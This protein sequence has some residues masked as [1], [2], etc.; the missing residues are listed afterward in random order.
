MSPQSIPPADLVAADLTMA[1]RQLLRRLR[2]ETN[3]SELSLSQ[4]AAL[5]RLEQNGSMTTADLARAELMKPQSMGV[6]VASLEREGLIERRPHPSDRRQVHFML[7]EEGGAMRSQHRSLK[8]DWLV[9]ALAKLD[10]ADMKALTAAIPLIRRIG[11][12]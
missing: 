4:M 7:T 10:A 6:I 1:I 2:A 11:E 8:R 12:S 5:S 3:P 9:T